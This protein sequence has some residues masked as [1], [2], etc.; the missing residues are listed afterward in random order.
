MTK[1]HG[2][3]TDAT[4]DSTLSGSRARVLSALQQSP[5]PLGVEDLAERVQLHPNTVRFHLEALVESKLVSQERESRDVPGRPRTLYRPTE[6]GNRAGQR[7]YRLLAEILT[8]HLASQALP[9][10]AALDAGSSWGRLLAAAGGEGGLPDAEATGRLV[11]ILAEI[12]FA[13]EHTTDDDG[14]QVLLHH[15]PFREAAEQNPEVVCGIH[16]GLMRGVLA[17]LGSDVT[18]ESLTPFVEPGLCVTKLSPAAEHSQ[19]A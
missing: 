16:L 5:T 18:A 12:G 2:P 1:A 13:P 17:E 9:G 6:N 8:S 7:S 19:P 15:C 14:N 11:D 3:L 4:E 10:A